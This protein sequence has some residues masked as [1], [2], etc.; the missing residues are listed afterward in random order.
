MAGYMVLRI[1]KR[2]AKTEDIGH[3]SGGE[4][5]MSLSLVRSGDHSID[6][7]IKNYRFDWSEILHSTM[8]ALLPT[9]CRL[10]A[11]VTLASTPF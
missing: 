1:Q 2:K 6:T 9:M 7:A 11:K 8:E 5:V 4:D 10:L 3:D